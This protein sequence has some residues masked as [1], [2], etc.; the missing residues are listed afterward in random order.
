VAEF[1]FVLVLGV[2]TIPIMNKTVHIIPIKMQ[3]FIV[4]ASDL[5]INANAKENIAPMTPKTPSNVKK[6]DIKNLHKF[7]LITR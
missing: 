7:D 2:A 1:L 6:T 5:N 4:F 3:I